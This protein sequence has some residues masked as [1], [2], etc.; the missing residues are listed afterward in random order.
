MLPP[1]DIEQGKETSA[2]ETNVYAC[3]YTSTLQMIFSN[4]YAIL[5]RVHDFH[6]SFIIKRLNLK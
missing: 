4:I 1:D 5:F 2:F 6:L 3:A